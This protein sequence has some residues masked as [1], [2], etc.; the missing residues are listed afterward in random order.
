MTVNE[1]A[2]C[3]RCWVERE[4][5]DDPILSD[6][7]RVRIEH[8]DGTTGTLTHIPEVHGESVLEALADYYGRDLQ[9][10]SA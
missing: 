1:R 2:G 4:P 10:G 8:E 9:E 6:M 3:E 7:V 5:N